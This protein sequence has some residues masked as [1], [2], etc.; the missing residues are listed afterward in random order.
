MGKV[1]K[2]VS[3]PKPRSG[4]LRIDQM[5][6]IATGSTILVVKPLRFEAP[7]KRVA[8]TDERNAHEQK[9]KNSEQSFVAA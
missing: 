2:N 7:D 3:Y 9:R 1:A 6:T 8:E 4:E 5:V